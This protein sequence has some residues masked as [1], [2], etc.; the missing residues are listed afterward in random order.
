MER[1]PDLNAWAVFDAVAAGGSFTRAAAQLGVSVPTVSKTVAA[2]EERLGLSLFHRTSRRLSLSAAGEEARARAGVLVGGFAA[3][4]EGLRDTDGPPRGLIRMSAPVSFSVLH[5]SGMLTQFLADWP[6]I[7]LDLSV[8]DRRTDI[9]AEGMDLAL[10][11]G[12]LD[13]SSLRARRLCAIRIPVV[14]APAYLERRGVPQ[15]PEDLAGHD[16]IAYSQL[17]QPARWHLRHDLEGERLV[18]VQP[19]LRADNG[20]IGLAALRAGIGIACQ[21]EFFVWDDLK[22]GRLVE[23]L[24]PWYIAPVGAFIV[25]PPSRLQPRRVRLLIDTLVEA[26]RQVPWAL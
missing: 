8:T 10:R 17:A 15:V 6:D 13:D 20:D 5:L 23:I 22:A 9:I 24:T 3:L 16:V 7:E 19:R 21:P 2:L 4:E 11:I 14:A 1:R 18:D 26:F 25:T 12:R